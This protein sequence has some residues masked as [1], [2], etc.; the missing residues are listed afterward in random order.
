MALAAYYSRGA[1]AA[2]QVLQGFDE[3]RFRERLETAR[4]GVTFGPDAADSVEGRAQLDLLIRL[5]ARLYPTLVIRQSDGDRVASEAADLARRINPDI[6]LVTGDPDIEIVV[7]ARAPTAVGTTVIHSGSNG[8][9]ALFSPK[10]PRNIGSSA[11]PFGAGAAACLAAGNAFRAVFVDA[12]ALD[13]EVVFSTLL[14]EPRP[15]EQEHWPTEVGDIVLVGLGAIG[16]AAAW[17]LARISASGRLWL[18]DHQSIDLGNLQRYVLA[19]RADEGS[20]KVQVADR[21]LGN[22]LVARPM[23][24]PLAEFLAAEGHAWNGMLLALDSAGD[25][26]AAQ[27]SLPRWIANAWTQ[28]GDLGVSTHDFLSA[29]C[30][31]CLYLPE[32]ALEN[33][34]QIIARALGVPERLMEVR[35]L[36]H[37]GGGVT[38]EF[39]EA[40]ASKHQ[41]D[42]GHL[43]DFEGKPVRSLYV[44]GFCGGAVLPLGSTGMPRQDV[45]VPLAHQSALAGVLLA[46]VAVA[47]VGSDALGT[48]VTRLDP[49]RPLP[50]IPTQPA[51]KDPRGICICQDEDYRASYRRK[52]AV[53]EADET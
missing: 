49:L 33:E 2:A 30:V 14:R 6:E 26:R 24:M 44:E 9:D 21:Y 35:V 1:L 19:E 39:L 27:A 41:V 31:S 23:P 40:I 16:N 28:P 4:V 37:T 36:L 47:Q 15:T 25:R 48:R 53:P 20:V 10:Q 32:H 8:W 5:L 29:A 42:R 50:A 34:D 52:Y 17:A 45:H 13:P 51:A 38:R 22:G 3:T 18:I 7:G 12:N 11:N 46:A 43:L